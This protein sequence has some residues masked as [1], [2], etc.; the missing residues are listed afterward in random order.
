MKENISASPEHD[1]EKIKRFQFIDMTASWSQ[2]Q[3]NRI[4]YKL[5]C[6]S[7][8]RD[9]QIPLLKCVLNRVTHHNLIRTSCYYNKTIPSM[10]G[11]IMPV[12][13]HDLYFTMIVSYGDLLW[14]CLETG[15][16]YT[17][18]GTKKGRCILLTLSI[19]LPVSKTQNT[20]M[21]IESFTS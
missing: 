18:Q 12:T 10:Q 9:S 3:T 4:P 8:E 1:S 14:L 13:S 7:F 20:F 2:K 6:F 19:H 17:S 16:F 15:S 11:E 5:G 21:W